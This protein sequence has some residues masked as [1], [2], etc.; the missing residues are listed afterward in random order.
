M[1]KENGLGEGLRKIFLAGVGALA[2]TGEKS[3]ELVDSLI[4]KGELTVDQGRELN[5]ELTHKVKNNV[6]TFKSDTIVDTVAAMT[7]AER[8]ALIARLNDLEA[9]TVKVKVEVEEEDAKE[10]AETPKP[11]AKEEN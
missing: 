10:T 5:Q 3:K 11:V 2:M 9:E 7:P 1:D 4:E 6:A 8:Q